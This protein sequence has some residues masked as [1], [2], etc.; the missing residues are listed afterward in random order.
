[1]ETFLSMIFKHDFSSSM[2]IWMLFSMLVLVVYEW[3]DPSEYEHPG[4]DRPVGSSFLGFII[5]LLITYGLHSVGIV[6]D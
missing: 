6:V 1:M 5:W 3:L 2:T 4:F